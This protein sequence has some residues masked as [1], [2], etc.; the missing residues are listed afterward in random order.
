MHDG[1]ELD[2]HGVP[3]AVICTEEFVPSAKAQAAICGNPT[4]PFAVVPHPIG[5]LT[6]DELRKRAEQALPQV[7]GIL[8]GAP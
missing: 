6:L 2:R 4:Y 3:A 7:L 1:I 8:T 5:S